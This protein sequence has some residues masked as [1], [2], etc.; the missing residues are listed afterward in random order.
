MFTQVNPNDYLLSNVFESIARRRGVDLTDLEYRHLESVE[1][2]AL[3]MGVRAME[4]MSDWSNLRKVEERI[5][6]AGNNGFSFVCMGAKLEEG[7]GEMVYAVQYDDSKVNPPRSV[8]AGRG[9][10]FD[11]FGTHVPSKEAIQLT[12]FAL[13]GSTPKQEIVP[14]EAVASVVKSINRFLGIDANSLIKAYDKTKQLQIRARLGHTAHSC[15]L[16][17]DLLLD[18][19]GPRETKIKTMEIGLDQLGRVIS[20]NKVPYFHT[21]RINV[22]WGE[23]KA[24][25]LGLPSMSRRY[26]AKLDDLFYLV[27]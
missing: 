11:I 27:E 7:V 15:L 8:F 26:G 14:L 17:E 2:P 10:N 25:Y 5:V 23:F 16:T 4:R 1:D 20:V 19:E 18:S 3:K 22:Q 9:L 6:R 12:L 21:P 13:Q 24:S